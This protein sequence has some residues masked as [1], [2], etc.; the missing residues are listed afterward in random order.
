MSRS[1]QRVWVA[2]GEDKK[3]LEEQRKKDRKARSKER[4]RVR[5]TKECTTLTAS[6]H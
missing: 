5:A 6:D 1:Q 2:K 3:K 4:E